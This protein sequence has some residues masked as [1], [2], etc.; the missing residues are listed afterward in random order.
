MQVELSGCERVTS[1][2]LFRPY[3]EIEEGDANVST[4]IDIEPIA[5]LFLY[6]PF[7]EVVATG[8][9]RADLG[10]G[11][12]AFCATAC[13]AAGTA[14]A[15]IASRFRF[16]LYDDEAR[17]VRGGYDPSE[18]SL[19]RFA[20]LQLEVGAEAL[21][22]PIGFISQIA[23]RPFIYTDLCA[24]SQFSEA[25]AFGRRFSAYGAG[26]RLLIASPVFVA[27]SMSYG[28]SADG[29]PRFCLDIDS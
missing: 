11:I 12:G 18:L 23:L 25:D 29:H 6:A 19:D 3:G 22:F 27:A 10:F 8:E 1:G 2:H 5:S 21:R 24:G 7:A 20:S 28:I 13:A 4:L 9:L 16:D 15:P 26:I 14:S 17:R